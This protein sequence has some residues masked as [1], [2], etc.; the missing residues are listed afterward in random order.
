MT[1]LGK[2]RV[3]K[4]KFVSLTR[5]H[6]FLNLSSDD[7]EVVSTTYLESGILDIDFLINGSAHSLGLDF[8]LPLT[9]CITMVYLKI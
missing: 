1:S 8:I 5:N 4:A 6:F 9:V 7:N 3:K 2:T